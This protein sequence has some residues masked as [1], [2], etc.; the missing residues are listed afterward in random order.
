MGDDLGSKSATGWMPDNH[1]TG[2]MPTTISVILA[3]LFAGCSLRH[4]EQ[5]KR[6]LYLTVHDPKGSIEY[7][8]FRKDSSY[9]Y[10][11]SDGKMYESVT[12]STGEET[13]SKVQVFLI[14]TFGSSEM[15]TAPIG[16]AYLPKQGSDT[17]TFPSGTKVT[18]QY[19]R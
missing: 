16:Q 19:Y 8:P 9:T 1:L 12:M 18:S 17:F 15:M 4:A 14:T 3:L 10:T 6:G 7:G 5:S 11:N 2:K 13:R